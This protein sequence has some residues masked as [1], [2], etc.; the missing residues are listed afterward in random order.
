[1]LLFFFFFFSIL[2]GGSGPPGPPSWIRL[3]IL[4]V[5]VKYKYLSSYNL[6]IHNFKH[7]SQS[8]KQE[9][10]IYGIHIS[11]DVSRRVSSDWNAVMTLE[12]F[13]LSLRLL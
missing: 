1:M 7:S 11:E 4:Y 2:K 3:W 12:K 5:C 13:S 6:N 8:E 10:Y 9:L